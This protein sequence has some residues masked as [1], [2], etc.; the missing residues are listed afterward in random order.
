MQDNL[1]VRRYTGLLLGMIA[2]ILA[3]IG[4]YTL[5]LVPM[6]TRIPIEWHTRGMRER[7]TEVGVWGLFIAPVVVLGFAFYTRYSRAWLPPEPSQRRVV[8]ICLIL[9]N[10]VFA[11]FQYFLARDAIAIAAGA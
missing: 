11:A 3:A 1:A 7:S 10:L 9:I 6:D 4:L 5:T 2:V 8:W